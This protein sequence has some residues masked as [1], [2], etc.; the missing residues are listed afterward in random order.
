MQVCCIEGLA[1]HGGT[2]L[3]AVIREGHGEASTGEHMGQPLNRES[4]SFR[5][6][7]R[8]PSRKA[9]RTGALLQAPGRP[10]AVGELGTCGR[11]L[12]GNREISW[13]TKAARRHWP[14]SGRRGAD[15]DDARPREV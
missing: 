2:E 9:I 7:T 10:G 1:N 14:A 8:C 11:S 5:V 15:A 3:C 6:P 13:L 4:L 12:Y